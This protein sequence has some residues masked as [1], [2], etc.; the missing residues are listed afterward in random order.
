METLTKT[1]G[2][3]HETTPDPQAGHTVVVFDRSNGNGEVF[4]Y[5]IPPGQKPPKKPLLERLGVG[6]V[7]NYWACAV[8]A[9]PS[10]H[11]R[12]TETVRMDDS[13]HWFTLSVDLVYCVADPTLLVVRRDLDPLGIVRTRAMAQLQ[14]ELGS[15]SWDEIVRSF[16]RVEQQIQSEVLTAVR[17]VASENGLRIVDI[18]L[19]AQIP[20]EF[21]APVIAAE[22][23]VTI[24]ATSTVTTATKAVEAG[25]VTQDREIAIQRQELDARVAAFERM[26]RVGDAAADAV[27][28][29]LKNSGSAIQNP[30]E[31]LQAMTGLTAAVDQMRALSGGT[32]GTAISAP[33]MN[34]LTAGGQSGLGPV[35]LDLFTKTEG[36]SC[37]NG[38]KLRLRAAMLQLIAELLPEEEPDAAAVTS[39]RDRVVRA[40]ASVRLTSE[41]AEYLNN[42]TRT[43]Q[44]RERLR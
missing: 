33:S 17:V 20:L 24:Q 36:M 9:A 27:A 19:G 29:A 34:L 38:E 2:L 28:T 4:L 8:T 18:G 5:E 15:R 31:L 1:H 14:R 3:F 12:F 25:H 37:E 10:L 39:A 6:A 42:F 41:Q 32:F 26:L 21:N 7:P 30:A 23:I 13:L 16:R 43:K 22:K 44:L 40:G 11:A 35:L